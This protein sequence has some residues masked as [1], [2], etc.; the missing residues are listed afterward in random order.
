MLVSQHAIYAISRRLYA[1]HIAKKMYSNLSTFKASIGHKSY[2]NP[3][4][5]TQKHHNV[6]EIQSATMEIDKWSKEDNEVPTWQCCRARRICLVEAEAAKHQAMPS[7]GSI[8]ARHKH[9]QLNDYLTTTYGFSGTKSC[10]TSF[11]LLQHIQR[12]T[13]RN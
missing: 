1:W 13:I 8:P 3:I 9:T 7:T 2:P 12:N 6:T 5:S 10:C 4:S 11:Q